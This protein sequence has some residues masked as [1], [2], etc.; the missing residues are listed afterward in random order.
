M[1]AYSL[2]I[3]IGGTDLKLAR[4]HESCLD[5][6][7]VRRFAMPSMDISDSGD[8]KLIPRAILSLVKHAISNFLGEFGNPERVLISGQMGSWILT[9]ENGEEVTEIISWQDY[10]Y[11]RCPEEIFIKTFEERYCPSTGSLKNNGHE[12][13]PGVPWRGLASEC[14][15]FESG[16]KYLFHTL[17]SWVTWHLTGQTNHVIHTTDAAATG[18]IDIRFLTWLEMSSKFEKMVERPK[19]LTKMERIGFLLGTEIPVHI[20]VGDQQASMLGSGL[21][22]KVAVLN[23]GTGGQ[24]AKLAPNLHSSSNKIR[25][26]FNGQYIET[27]THIPSGR[28]LAKFLWEAN[29]YFGTSFDWEWIWKTADYANIP[30]RSHISDW[31]FEEYLRDFFF[32]KLTAEEA[33][34]VFMRDLSENFLRGL[35]ELNLKDIQEITL[36]GGLAQ[37]WKYISRVINEKFNT[38]VFAAITI[39]TTLNG[40]AMLEPQAISEE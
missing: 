3:D 26:Y 7:S 36:A 12:D 2:L 8:A 1:N 14:Q 35:A 24:V 19:I 28:Y 39:E 6:T 13:W 38:Q 30:N 37:R 16:K 27:I 32:D 11:S 17:T 10:S 33:K 4:A 29:Q 31:K 18:M 40:L 21:G 9:E 22:L 15:R 5:S 20:A 34:Q 25:P 23:A